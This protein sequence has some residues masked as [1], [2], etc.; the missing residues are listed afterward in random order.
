M[1]RDLPVL[2]AVDRPD[3]AGAVPIQSPR[4]MEKIRIEQHSFSGSLWFAPWLFT[5]SGV[6]IVRM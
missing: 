1:F 3:V 6:S 4:D 2:S 5:S